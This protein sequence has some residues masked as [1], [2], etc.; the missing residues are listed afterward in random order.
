MLRI[1]I[2]RYIIAIH[3]IC[4]CEPPLQW[5]SCKLI[6]HNCQV[7]AMHL[8]RTN[9]PDTAWAYALREMDCPAS[10]L[11]ELAELWGKGQ[12]FGQSRQPAR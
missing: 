3:D 11:V 9:Y 1:Q 5:A 8:I 2:D 6:A 4:D 12:S 10:E 7:D